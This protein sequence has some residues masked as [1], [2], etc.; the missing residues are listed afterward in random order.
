MHCNI[1]SK[2]KNLV[3]QVNTKQSYRQ[4]RDA[5]EFSYMLRT[6][7]LAKICGPIA[8][9]I[10]HKVGNFMPTYFFPNSEG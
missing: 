1:K 10:P 2:R 6:E 7:R 4:K 9:L 3:T 8:H 5:A